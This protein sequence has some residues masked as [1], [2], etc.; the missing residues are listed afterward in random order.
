[1]TTS[2][3]FRKIDCLRLPVPDVD[4]ALA[5][6]RDGL[7]HELVWR[8]SDAAG[9]RMPD[10]DAELV[11]FSV[12]TEQEANLLVEDVRAAVDR[13]IDA[14]AELVRGPFDISI[15]LCAIVCD[16]FRNR[17]VLL[18]MSKGRLQ[19]DGDGYVTGSN[20]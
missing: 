3:L 6:Y 9:M 11:V 10:T 20:E 2:P 13:L 8:T 14:G 1:V 16:P 17:L 18:D 4:T 19:T 5:F 12:G 7:G 15:G